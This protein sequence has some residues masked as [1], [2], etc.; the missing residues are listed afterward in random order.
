[1]K[2]KTYKAGGLPFA[3]INQV[4]NLQIE[5]SEVTV[6]SVIWRKISKKHPES[7]SA[8]SV[9]LNDTITN[10]DFVGQSHMHHYNIEL[11]KRTTAGPLLVAVKIRDDR[12][13]YCEPL[14]ASAYLI[15]AIDVHSRQTKGTIKRFK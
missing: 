12:A 1:M 2:R 6:H 15:D 3:R 7:L 8:V 11:I 5:H 14:V 13:F 9:Y 10:P 4:L